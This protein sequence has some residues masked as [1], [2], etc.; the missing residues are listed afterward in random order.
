[1][2]LVIVGSQNPAKV[3]PVQDV[4]G[5]LQP[6][7]VVVG[8]DVPSG[9][10]DQPLGEEETRW[11][12]VN[13]AWAA[14][15]LAEAEQSADAWGIGLEG[16]VRLN[17][18]GNGWLFGMVAVAHSGKLETVR[19]AEMRLPPPVLARVQGG[20]ELGS[21]MDD[22]L[23]T[24]DVKRGVGSVGVLTGGLA[25]R[26]DVWRMGLALALA[27]FLNAELYGSEQQT[28]PLSML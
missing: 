27:P 17:A 2:R 23:G 18:D 11:G 9:V 19:T 25:D 4:F 14:L 26:A 6:Q 22:L 20:E 21:V 15:K 16:G 10:P 7:A 28:R 24:V 3:R 5:Q 13:R 8:R 12:A 1:M